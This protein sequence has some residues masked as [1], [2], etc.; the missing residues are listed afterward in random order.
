MF[1]RDATLFAAWNVS[2]RERDE[3]PLVEEENTMSV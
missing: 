1:Q 2:V 3:L